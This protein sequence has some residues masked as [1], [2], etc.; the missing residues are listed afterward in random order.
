MEN[1]VNY[2]QN[3]LNK[4]DTNR[5][6]KPLADINVDNADIK[7]KSG[8]WNS[9]VNSLLNI[10]SYEK[11]QKRH[12]KILSHKTTSLVECQSTLNKFL[13]HDKLK[14]SFKDVSI[15]KSNE[16]CTS[17]VTEID[18]AQEKDESGIVI[19]DNNCIMIED[20]Q[21]SV[22]YDKSLV[23][24]I[25]DK[26]KNALLQVEEAFKNQEDS[27]ILNRTP[28]YKEKIQQTKEDVT[29][30]EFCQ[31]YKVPYYKMGY[32]QETCFLCSEDM[33]VQNVTKYKSKG[34]FNNT[35]VTIDG[36]SFTAT[37]RVFNNIENINQFNKKTSLPVQT[38]IVD[39]N[40]FSIN[41]EKE[42]PNNNLRNNDVFSKPVLVTK[43]VDIKSQELFMS[44]EVPDNIF[45]DLNIELDKRK[46][47]IIE[48]SDS[49]EDMA[50][51]RVL[52]VTAD[53]HRS[54][55]EL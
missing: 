36:N 32:L 53:I 17:E 30:N 14:K 24:T 45:N 19:D 29:N 12:R 34:Q 1:S 46:N 54:F 21:L 9:K 38:D 48:D 4:N 18:K 10:K 35:C 7:R 33:C 44:E 47:V 8:I 15:K 31:Q 37:I 16:S 42:L 6:R 43:S 11:K 13:T 28:C 2:V 49:S 39:I 27:I 51:A 5:K 25:V 22:D 3:W 55:E 50:E 23:N 26:D 40:N 20:S 41:C 52:E